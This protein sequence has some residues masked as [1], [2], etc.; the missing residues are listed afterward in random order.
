MKFNHTKIYNK[1]AN[2][3][4]LYCVVLISFERF[5]TRILIRTSHEADGGCRRL[6]SG[7][8]Q[9]DYRYCS[10]KSL[11]QRQWTIIADIVQQYLFDIEYVYSL[12][13]DLLSIHDVYTFGCWPLAVGYLAAAEVVPFTI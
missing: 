6:S 2:G 13:R 8:R 1:G 10:S 12:N 5:N 3:W 7:H 4:L 9:Q 11:C